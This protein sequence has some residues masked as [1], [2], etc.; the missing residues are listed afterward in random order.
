MVTQSKDLTIMVLHSGG[1]DSTVCVYRGLE[2]GYDVK[3]LGINYGQKHSI[4]L[5][6]AQRQCEKLGISRHVVEVKW[7]KPNRQVPLGRKIEELR[8]NV[9]P[10]FLPGRNVVFLSIA[11]A[12]AAGWG[13]SEVWLG[14]NEVDFSGYP[15]CSREFLD[16]FIRMMEVASPGGPT[17]RAP[18]ISMSKPEIARE[19]RRLGIGQED[20]W[21]CYRPQLVG[22]QATPCGHCDACLLHKHA[23]ECA[24]NLSLQSEKAHPESIK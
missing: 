16:S 13:A 5:A 4:E 17:I 6:Y 14:I 7:H 10:A 15:D 11:C 3:S 19:A 24:V 18:L 2:Q 9:S 22:Q 8:G 23:W 1:L 12:E 20:T 21:S